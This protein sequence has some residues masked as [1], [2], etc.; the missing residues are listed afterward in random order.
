MR[1]IAAANW[2]SLPVCVVVAGA[3]GVFGTPATTPGVVLYLWR[4]D[5]VH[6]KAELALFVYRLYYPSGTQELKSYAA[7]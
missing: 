5:S 1:S 4:D 2:Q 6:Q 7:A 3:G